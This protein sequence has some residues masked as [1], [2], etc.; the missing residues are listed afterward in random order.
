MKVNE[1]FGMKMNEDVNGNRKLFWEGV[2]I[3]K[4]G[5]VESFSRVKDGWEAGTG[6]GR[7]EKDL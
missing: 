2:S 7:S 5:Q 4:G 6:R 1:K 3:A